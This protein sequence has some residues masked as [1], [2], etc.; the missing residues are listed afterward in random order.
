[1][2]SNLE[3]N[4]TEDNVKSVLSRTYRFEVPEYQREYAWT[5]D[6]LEEFW[7]DLMEVI[8]TGQ[9]HFLGSIVVVKESSGMDE[10]DVLE[11]VDGQQRLVTISILLC[12]IRQRFKQA[13]ESGEW[14]RD[15]NPADRIDSQYLWESDEDMNNYQKITLSTFDNDDY[16]TLLSGRLPTNEDSQLVQAAQYLSDRVQEI[17]IDTVN[18][19]R[20]RLVDSM[21][22]VTI[23]CN[24]EAS[25]FKLFETLNDRGLPLNAIDLMKNY[26]FG[27]ATSNDDINYDV[28]RQYWENIISEIKP[29]L[30]K[31][32]R[33]FRHYMM[34]AS[35]PDITSPVTQ[36]TLYDR[37]CEI[38]DGI[39]AGEYE[40]TVQDYIG[41]MVDKAPLYVDITQADTDLYTGRENTKINQLLSN[42]NTL[43]ATQERTILLRL[44]TEIDT[45]TKLIR[46]LSA[47]ESFIFRWR[48]T[49]QTTGTDVDEIHAELASNVFNQ[50]DPIKYLT[51]RLESKAPND[52]EVEVSVRTNSFPRNGRTRYVL[53]KM[54][55]DF[56]ANNSSKRVDSEAIEIEHIAP[57]NPFGTKKYSA[58][59]DYLNIG[60]ETYKEYQN[61]IGN[62]TI[63]NE[64]MNARAQDKPF[65][66]KKR[67]YESSEFAMT[68]EICDFDEWSI[69]TIE[70]RRD[71]LAE[72]TPQIWNFDV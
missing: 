64:R 30:T 26:L 31:P 53:A 2:P 23:E 61:N 12:I 10:L 20:K 67:E 49:N 37:F 43:G 65:E 33:F 40:I 48:V 7:T 47:I 29:E 5:E 9:S 50:S 18:E 72:I 45:S 56:F 22:L 19:I 63:L 25:A 68:R 27:V 3:I 36:Y 6:Q 11:I 46:S 32:S 21:T 55:N 59:V 39:V 15:E 41:D 66:Q 58:W 62:L 4:A 60:E 44:F 42:L 8:R 71:R 13:E 17:D 51:E 16:Q 54:E 1:M 38:I 69:E 35:V 24:S 70:E 14:R 28:I 57:R 34:M 52:S